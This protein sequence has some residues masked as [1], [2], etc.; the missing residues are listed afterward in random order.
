[1]EHCSSMAWSCKHLFKLSPEVSW[2]EEHINRE[3]LGGQVAT[4]IQQNERNE[5]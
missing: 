1:M 4:A 3:A 2:N 5:D